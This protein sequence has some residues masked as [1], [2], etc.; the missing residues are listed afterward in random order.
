LPATR[1]RGAGPIAPSAFAAIALFVTTCSNADATIGTV[2][3]YA[4]SRWMGLVAIVVSVFIEGE[5]LGRW[6]HPGRG[7]EFLRDKA[8]R[9]VIAA[10]AA[11]FLLG[12]MLNAMAPADLGEYLGT[13]GVLIRH[14]PAFISWWCI[15]SVPVEAPIVLLMLRRDTPHRIRLLTGIIIANVASSI[16]I[17]GGILA[18]GLWY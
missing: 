2:Q 15:F 12:Y 14:L 8:F 9:A 6:L 17:A 1:L 13:Q 11:C 3:V 5:V 7:G 4:A 16:S 10:N 18:F